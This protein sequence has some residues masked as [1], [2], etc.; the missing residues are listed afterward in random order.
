MS[1]ADE[2]GG[3]GVNPEKVRS[4]RL[5]G[6]FYAGDAGELERQVEGYLAGGRRL[7]AGCDGGGECLAV[8]APHAGHVYSGAVAG[9]A[10]AARG[11]DEEAETVAVLSPSHAYGFR[12]VAAGDYG[13]QDTPLGAMEV[14]V[15]RVEELCGRGLARVEPRAHELEHGIEVL[16]PLVMRR[17]PRARLLPLVFGDEEGGGRAAVE[18]ARTLLGAA[19]VVVVVS[20]D[21][22]HFLAEG[23]ARV[24]DGETAEIVAGMRWGELSGR[25]ACGHVP[26]RAVMRGLGAGELGGLRGELLAYANSAGAG[27]DARSVVGYGA[28]GFYGG[29]KVKI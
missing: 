3:V 18:L 7:A 22:S 5:A 27:G 26:L 16:V 23:A 6:R 29:E 12:G 2:R 20:S 25:R 19:G 8:V 21:L 4:G 17:W 15:G 28:F 10:L 24:R 14:D 1:V 13:W 11:L 9:A